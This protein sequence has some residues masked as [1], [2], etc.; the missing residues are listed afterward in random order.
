MKAEISSDQLHVPLNYR[1]SQLY[2]IHTFTIYL[3]PINFNV[4]FQIYAFV[5]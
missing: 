1:R 4:N 5:Y 2:S 3:F